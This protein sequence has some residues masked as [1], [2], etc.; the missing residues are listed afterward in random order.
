MWDGVVMID[1]KA[2]FDSIRASLFNGVLSQRQVDG[3][4]YLLDEHARNN[5]VRGC[6]VTPGRARHKT[7]TGNW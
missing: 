3:M 4:N 7:V 6:A 5:H 1:R 2:F